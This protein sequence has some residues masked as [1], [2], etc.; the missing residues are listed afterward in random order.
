MPKTKLLEPEE[1]EKYL[2]TETT[3]TFTRRELLRFHTGLMYY[4]NNLKATGWDKTNNTE[5]YD[6]YLSVTET[7]NNLGKILDNI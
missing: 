6:Y 3:C 4:I 1:K 2:Q 7:L 5:H